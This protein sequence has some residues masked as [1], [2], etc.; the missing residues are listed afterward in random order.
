[1]EGDGERKMGLALRGLAA[2]GIVAIVAALRARNACNRRNEDA[3]G[4]RSS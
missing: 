2:G 1:M 4:Q 3:N